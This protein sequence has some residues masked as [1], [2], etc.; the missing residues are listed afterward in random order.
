G[1]VLGGVARPAPAVNR[2][3][4]R[5]LRHAPLPNRRLRRLLRAGD[6]RRVRGRGPDPPRHRLRGVRRR[7]VQ[8]HSR[9]GTAVRFHWFLPTSGDGRAIIGGGRGLQRGHGRPDDVPYRPP[10]IDYLG[11]VAQAA[12]RLGFEAVLTPTGTWCEDAWLVAAALSQVTT[13]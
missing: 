8:R 11:Q 10:S 4:G 7:P 1:E 12:E 2:G 5:Q 3:R 13:R 9:E 6:G